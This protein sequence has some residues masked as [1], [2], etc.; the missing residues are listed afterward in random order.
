M[1]QRVAQPDDETRCPFFGELAD[2][3]V[4]CGVLH[5]LDDPEWAAVFRACHAAGF[6]LSAECVH[7]PVHADIESLAERV[8]RYLLQAHFE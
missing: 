3:G 8:N 7:C 2:S 1:N 5:S 6:C 4:V